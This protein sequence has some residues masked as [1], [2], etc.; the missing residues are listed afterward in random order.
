MNGISPVCLKHLI[1]PQSYLRKVSARMVSPIVDLVPSISMLSF[2]DVGIPKRGGKNLF[3]S[4]SSFSVQLS[5]PVLA[6]Y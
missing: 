4:H 1:V 2:I 3:I 5:L 6:R